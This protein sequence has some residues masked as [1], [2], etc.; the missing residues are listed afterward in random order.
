[1]GLS[2][3]FI[4]STLSKNI[5]NASTRQTYI[6]KV[7]VLTKTF[8]SDIYG[9]IKQPGIYGDK[10]KSLYP[11]S[12]ASQKNVITLILA[13]FKRVPILVQKKPQAYQ[14]WFAIHKELGSQITAPKECEITLDDIKQKYE[15]LK[16]NKPHS[17]K[18]QSMLYVLLSLIMHIRKRPDYGLL[19][20][21]VP[22][23][24]TSRSKDYIVLH[25]DVPYMVL[26][27]KKLRVPRTL[28]EDLKESIDDYPR[29]FVFTDTKNEHYTKT[30]SYNVFVIRAFQKAF[31]K[32][33]GVNN[34]ANIK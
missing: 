27:N 25:D 15:E 30:N 13:I 6:N 20:V 33:I 9:I 32:K 24:H 31:G 7:E 29:S 26:N 11:K 8:R 22:P 23:N 21:V 14:K 16:Q 10:I 28:Y 1:M 2:N 12:V 34:L 18:Q 17:T 19:S 5:S 3:Q 4:I